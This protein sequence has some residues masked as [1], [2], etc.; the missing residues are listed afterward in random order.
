MR[1]MQN[2][3]SNDATASPNNLLPLVE[4]ILHAHNKVCQ[5]YK[6]QINDQI[7]YAMKE[8][9][10]VSKCKCLL[11]KSH[12]KGIK[13]NSILGTQ[14]RKCL[15]FCETSRDLNLQGISQTVT[16]NGP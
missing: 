7:L 15:A 12:L 5:P 10:A 6:G 14:A 9:N 1:A 8:T 16:V 13:I 11:N 2:Q 4:T 3:I